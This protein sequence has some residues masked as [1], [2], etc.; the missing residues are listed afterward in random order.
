MT[1]DQQSASQAT[2]PGRAHSADGDGPDPLA[3]FPTE[4]QVAAR[5]GTQAHRRRL[6]WIRLMALAGGATAAALA[7]WLAVPGAS[8]YVRNLIGM[9]EPS[10]PST[11]VIQSTPSGWEVTEDGRRLGTTPLR[12][13]LAA[14]RHTLLLTKGTS[15]RPLEVTLPP[16]VEVVHH[17][18]LP[19]GPPSG[20]LH[21]ATLPPGAAVDIDGVSRGNTPVDVAGLAPGDHAVV[22]TS[23]DRV[24]N[25]RVTIAPG[26]TATLLVPLGQAV[27]PTASVGWVTI[28]APIELQVYEGDSLVGSSRNQRIMLMP[29]RHSLRLANM[30]LGFEGTA[31]VTIEPGAMAKMAV[32]VPNGALSVNALPWAEVVLDGTVIGETPIANYS[33]SLG[34]HELVLRNPRYAEQRRTVVVSL[35]APVR[36]GVDLRQ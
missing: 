31:A 16:G 29:G 36:I 33:V 7:V 18:D 8:V 34:S 25:E 19:V 9:P 24:V 21:V 30:A 17:L 15:T 20:A 4:A 26:G 5:T 35:T 28:A 22:L 6:A 3:A 11:L 27:I 13:P 23:R 32:R 2:S 14:G 12:V 1:H 10:A